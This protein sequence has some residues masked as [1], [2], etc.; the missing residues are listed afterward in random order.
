MPM[1]VIFCLGLGLMFQ[2]AGDG[3]SAANPR[4]AFLLEQADD[5]TLEVHDAQGTPVEATRRPE[6][7]LRFTNPLHDAQSDGALLLWV[8]KQLPLFLASYSIR[9]EKE[10]F[11]EL[12]IVS[13]VA[14]QCR[15]GGRL[16]WAPPAAS[17]R[18][19]S[20]PEAPAPAANERLRLIQMRSLVR[21]FQAGKMRLM[22]TPLY[23]YSATE[24]G[25]LDGALFAFTLTN[26]P[27]VIISISAVQREGEASHWEYGVCRMNSFPQSVRLDD[28]S[29]WSV[30]GY[31]KN[32][33]SPNDPY[34]EQWDAKLPEELKLAAEK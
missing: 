18:T 28:R 4:L 19:V 15:R 33:R 27:E 14:I 26:D 32:P 2:P 20:I 5:L 7:V 11:R 34:V 17:Y 10:V 22:P 13:P 30:E 25:V 8:N 6:P 9:N 24:Q 23:R 3:E 12:S 16:V 21:R 29:V 1:N 31:W